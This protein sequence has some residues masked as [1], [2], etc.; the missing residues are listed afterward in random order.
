LECVIEEADRAEHE[1]ETDRAGGDICVISLE[2]ANEDRLD[3]ERGQWNQ[4][5]RDVQTHHLVSSLYCVPTAS[6]ERPMRAVFPRPGGTATARRH[7]RQSWRGG[8]R[9]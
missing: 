3:R 5:G 4:H 6:R 2:L 7:R 8:G 9:A 1:G